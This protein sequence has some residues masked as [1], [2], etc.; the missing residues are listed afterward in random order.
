MKKNIRFIVAVCLLGVLHSCTEVLDTPSSIT[1]EKIGNF[2]IKWRSQITDEQKTA[3]K[4]LL[5]D[6]VLINSGSF[7]MG[8]T[9]EQI[10]YARNN[11]YPNQYVSLS[12]YYIAAH[13]VD[14]KLYNTITGESVS[15]SSSYA[16]RIS[17]SQW[18]NFINILC[19]MTS[20]SFSLP[21]E[22]QW[23][24]AAR[25]AASSNNYIYP[26]SNNLEEIR[27][28]SFLEGSTVSNEIGIYNMGD[29]KSEWCLDLYSSFNSD[30]FMHNPISTSGKYKVVRGGNF[31]CTIEKDDYESKS[32]S[33][34]NYNLSFGT[35]YVKRDLDYRH[36]RIT[37]RSYSY[38]DGDIGHDYIG[39]RLVINL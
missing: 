18:Q 35:S 32:G 3:I 19:D 34:T 2:S 11:E 21:T 23:E 9:P 36:C 20:I 14:D 12:E 17:F 22:A 6:M 4:E 8:A 5:Y 25:G 39:C 38:T 30:Y 7:V 10:E 31:R 26:G 13:E 33:S 24:Y 28:T 29:L 27:S 1:F 37:S 16:S 15:A